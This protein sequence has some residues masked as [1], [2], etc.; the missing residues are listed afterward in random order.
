MCNTLVDG[1]IYPLLLLYVYT[2]L[3]VSST[4]HI[5]NPS[6]LTGP[7]S[8]KKQVAMTAA[9]SDRD[10]TCLYLTNNMNTQYAG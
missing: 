8:I 6:Q 9:G 2:H 10:I 7:K 5:D 1:F 3:V 4:L